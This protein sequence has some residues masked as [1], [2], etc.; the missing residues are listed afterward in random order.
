MLYQVSVDVG[1]HQTKE[2][3]QTDGAF[4]AHNLSAKCR[5]QMCYTSMCSDFAAVWP[6]W[7]P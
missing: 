7:F 4:P 5:S 2:V 6:V 3:D 1:Q